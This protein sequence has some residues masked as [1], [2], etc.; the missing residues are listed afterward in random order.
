MKALQAINPR[1][2]KEVQTPVPHL[3][4]NEYN[5]ILVRTAWGLTCGS[6]IPFF[7]GNKRYQSY[8]LLPG[9]P[10]HECTGEVVESSSEQFHAGDRVLAIPEGNLRLAEFFLAKADKA[11]VLD[12]A[13]DDLGAACIIQP[14]STVISAVDRLGNIQEK[15]LAVLGLGPIGLL[16]CWLAKKRGAGSVIGVDPLK[17]RCHEAE[18]LGATRTFPMRSAELIHQARAVPDAWKAAD[19]CI[20][21]VGHQMNTLNDCFE[22]VEKL[23]TVLAFGVPDQ[24]VYAFEYETF[25][26]KNAVLIAAVTPDWKEYLAK[27]QSLF[28]ENRIELS[29]LVTHRVP[30]GDAADAF[31]MY[32][33]R[34][35]GVLKV[36][37]DAR[38]W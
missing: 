12:S 23:G 16:F 29:R 15:S 1:I 26:R 10:I 36:A 11:I 25:F 4:K 38:G 19:I 18:S 27:A 37:L 8:P 32:E 22:M 3:P 13:I 5:Y 31:R 24:P 33:R 35:A 17:D 28:L 20:E 2:F 6:D 34:E 21:A 30:M 14:L 7:I 9:A